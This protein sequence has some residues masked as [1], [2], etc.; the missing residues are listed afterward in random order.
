MQKSKLFLHTFLMLNF[1]LLSACHIPSPQKRESDENHQSASFY[2]SEAKGETQTKKTA[3]DSGIPRSKTFSFQACLKNRSQSQPLVGQDFR[4]EETQEE[5]K[6]NDKG[7]LIWTEEVPFDFFSE[8]QYLEWTRHI[9]GTGLHKGRHPVQFAINPWSENDPAVPAVVDLQTTPLPQVLRGQ[10]EVQNALNGQSQNSQEGSKKLWAN[11]IRLQ[12]L[13]QK[14]TPQGALL[15]FELL[16]TPQMQVTTLAGDKNLRKINRG[17]FKTR[18]FLIHVVTENNQEMRRVFAISPVQSVSIR[19]DNL[20]LRAPFNVSALPT[21]GQVVLGLDLSAEGLNEN[22]GGFHGLYTLGDYDHIK[23]TIF[24]RLMSVVAENPQFRLSDYITSSSLEG[25]ASVGA[26]EPYVKAQIDIAPLEFKFLR[27]G[28]ETTS[29]REIHY[30]VKACFKNSLDQKGVRGHDFIVTKFRQSAGETSR[31]VTRNSETTSCIHWDEVQNFKFYGC[32][33]YLKG[34]V[35]IANRDLGLKQKLELAI[36]PWQSGPAFALDLR[37]V[38]NKE[39]LLAD[40]QQKNT[41]PSTLSLRSFSYSTLSYDYDIDRFLN[42]SFKKKLRFKL[43]A[44]ASVFNDTVKGRMES[45]QKLRPGVYLLKLAVIK[46]RDYYNQKSFVASVEKLVTNLD[47]DIKTDIEFTVADLKAISERNTLLIELDPV[48]ENKVT[49]D[50]NGRVAVKGHVNSLDELIDSTSEMIRIPFNGNFVL[51]LEKDSQELMPVDETLTNQYLA[52]A[53]L[54]QLL[55]RNSLV[56]EYI[57]HGQSVRAEHIK[58]QQNQA[59]PEYIASQN[60]LK[61]LSTSKPESFQELQAFLTSAPLKMSDAQVTADLQTLA[62][63]GRLSAPLAKGLCRYWFQ[64]FIQKGIWPSEIQRAVMNCGLRIQKPDSVFHIEKHLLVKDLGGFEFVKGLNEVLSINTSISLS[65]T[66]A[67]SHNLTRSTSLGMS[68]EFPFTKL[69]SVGINGNYGISTSNAINTGNST[70]LTN[71]LGVNLQKNEYHLHLKR[72]EECSI[73][74]VWPH[75][76]MKKGLLENTLR[77]SD[78]FDKKA[79]V[80]TQGLMICTG[81][82]NTTPLTR[83]ET[84][85]WLFQDASGYEMQDGGDVRNRNFFFALRGES[86]FHRLQ[87]FMRGTLKHPSSSHQELDKN[88]PF[89]QNLLSLFKTGI[90][91]SPG[92]YK[93]NAV[94]H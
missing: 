79:E 52:N 4:I 54:P 94:P 61:L 21:R 12:S 67:K 32:Q 65:R 69:F 89:Q 64:S 6:T 60:S 40:C 63:T 7:C 27:V 3:M 80:A 83:K 26:S 13:E 70:A 93:E 23:T 74:K 55:S 72:Y 11:E 10:E 77:P 28:K 75:L 38:D 16:I 17:S 35:E 19:N 34:F 30:S 44:V 76:F 46:N 90:P 1:A 24:L 20:F 49:V 85:Y 88:N 73:V 50:K 62:R 39:G 29:E 91:N 2:V 81:Q 45:A 71:Q 31:T 68:L 18:L 43:D 78:S 66:Y 36:N 25:K 59:T 87:Y 51:G 57:R 82:E 15:N 58:D 41:L 56:R 22:I 9:T 8:P 37:T 92:L 47:G 86:E 14:L 33:K 53:R 48:Q 5:L 84:Y 42:L